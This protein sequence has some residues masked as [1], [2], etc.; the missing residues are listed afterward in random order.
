VTTHDPAL[1]RI[2]GRYQLARV[3]AGLLQADVAQRV[4]I[5]RAS[6]A[7]FERGRQDVPLTR[8]LALCAAVGVDLMDIIRT[9]A[10]A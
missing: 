6:V 5:S 9:H 4:G 10:D 8:A 2:G 7:N 3:R 1:I